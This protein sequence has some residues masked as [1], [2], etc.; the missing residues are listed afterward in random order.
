MALSS[1]NKNVTRVR[2]VNEDSPLAGKMGTFVRRVTQSSE[3][4]VRMDE[5]LP[6][7]LRSPFPDESRRLHNTVL[8]PDECEAVG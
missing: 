4:W 5:E 7:A 3:A 2:V 6:E 1:F 8:F